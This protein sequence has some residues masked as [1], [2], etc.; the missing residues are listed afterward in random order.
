MSENEFE[1]EPIAALGDTPS[2]AADSSRRTWRERRI[3]LP[4]FIVSCIAL[5][6]AA[7]MMTW[8]FLGTIYNKKL[9]EQQLQISNWGMSTDD[10]LAL[11]DAIFDAYG[12]QE[13]SV[14]SRAVIDA[15]LKEYVR[16]TG[17]NYAFYYTEEEFLE[18][19][20]SNVGESQG[21]G[22]NIIQ[23]TAMIGGTSYDVVKVINVMKD[24]PA[25]EAGV[26]TGDLIV[27]V[28]IGEER[29]PVY[30]LGYDVAVKKMQ[31][32]KGTVAT[33]T[34][35]RPDGDGYEVKE[36]SIERREFTGWSVDSH[37]CTV[38]GYGDVGIVKI[39]QFD[40]TTPTQ[41]CEEVDSLLAA[42]CQ[43][44]VF[45]VRHNPGGDL[46]SI[47]A[48]LS[49]FLKS[50][51]VIIRTSDRNGQS[52]VSRVEAVTYEDEYA[53]CSVSKADIGKYRDFE[54]VILCNGS[55]ASAAELFTATFR[56]YEMAP[57]VGTTT[58]GK[59]SM[60]SIMSLA[61]FGCPGAL[62]LTTKMYYPPI[63]DSYEGIGIVPDVVIEQSEEA[64]KINIYE[65]KDDEDDQLMAALKQLNK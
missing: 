5:V 26:Q 15:A 64:S 14:D 25:Y 41:F 51:D 40:L 36:F 12:I 46:K 54:T 45:D 3:S 65:I 62:K 39:M 28:G 61:M 23:S 44:L 21:I 16:Q 53:G 22:I 55:T 13:V 60:Q 35:Y 1:K 37:V 27:F 42:G 10:S 49:Y 63:G 43:K 20:K 47:E 6:L 29:E 17:D 59:G 11:F 24:S 8:V 9:R 52:E 4:T 2:P 57:I 34:V 33:F 18:L 32:V 50:G 56:D 31:G 19:Q 48:V 58:F 7:V 38:D 30:E